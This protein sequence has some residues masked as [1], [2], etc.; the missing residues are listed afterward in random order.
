M[1]PSLISSM[2][3]KLMSSPSLHREGWKG[4]KRGKDEGREGRGRGEG[5][6]GR[7]GERREGEEEG[8]K[9]E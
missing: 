2:L 4:E 7:R 5:R 6:K 9:D 8:K 1:T 3:C